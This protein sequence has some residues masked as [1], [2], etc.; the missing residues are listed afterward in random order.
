MGQNYIWLQIQLLQI[1]LK[2]IQ[3]TLHLVSVAFRLFILQP[4]T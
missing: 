3:Y 2:V 4:T 1:Q